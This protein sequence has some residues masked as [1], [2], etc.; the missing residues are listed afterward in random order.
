MFDG[1]GES[2]RQHVRK[3]INRLLAVNFLSRELDRDDYLLA[4]RQIETLREFFR[5]IGW[6]IELDQVHECLFVTSSERAHRVS[7]S[8]EE[9]V[10]L[11]VLRLLYEEKR[12]ELSLSQFPLVTLHEIR[13]KYE[14][15]RLTFVNRTRLQ[16]LV[17]LAERF[18]L[19]RVLDSDLKA[20][21][22]RFQL[23]HTLLH[24]INA[25]QV[26]QLHKK[27]LRFAEGGEPTEVAEEITAG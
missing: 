27:I 5:G 3:V 9:T 17:K 1:L 20:D 11:L 22:C 2:E 23:H 6:E 25:E 19:L 8:K 10:W 7:L 24:A 4:R 13:N 15:F 26:E 14:A 12:S 16:E 21:D 18:Q